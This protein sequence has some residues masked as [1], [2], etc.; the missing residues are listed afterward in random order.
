MLNCFLKKESFYYKHL[1]Y[2]FIFSILEIFIIQYT[3]KK[4]YKLC[5]FFAIILL[6]FSMY[7]FSILLKKY[8][9]VF[10]KN[11]TIEHIEIALKIKKDIFIEEFLKDLNKEEFLLFSYICHNYLYI[12]SHKLGLFFIDLEV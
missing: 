5:V 3:I 9:Y 11:K 4:N 2:Y 1:L 8:I 7:N 6:I 10:L 12:Y